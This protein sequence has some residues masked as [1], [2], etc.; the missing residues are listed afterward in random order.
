MINVFPVQPK[1]VPP[2]GFSIW[3]A[4]RKKLSFRL[5]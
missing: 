4:K 2:A 3:R 1:A 5:N